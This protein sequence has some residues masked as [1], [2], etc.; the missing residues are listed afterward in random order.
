MARVVVVV[1]CVCVSG[2]D[3]GAVHRWEVSGRALAACSASRMRA[4][5]S[6]VRKW[7]PERPSVHTST[8]PWKDSPSER[9]QRSKVPAATN[10]TPYIFGGDWNEDEQNPECTITGTYHPITTIREVG[11]LVEFKP[12]DLNGEYRTWSTA[13]TTPSIRFDYLIAATA[14]RRGLVM[15]TS[16][17][18]EFSRISGLRVE[19]WRTG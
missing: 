16:N 10:S 18:G 5:S 9:R 15:V 19:D 17:T 3:S 1:V 2:D 13:T 14:L 12:T 8:R 11:H 7:W 4:V 6:R